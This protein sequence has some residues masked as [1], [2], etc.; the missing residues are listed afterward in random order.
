MGIVIFLVVAV[1][2]LGFLGRLVLDDSLV[3]VPPGWTGLVLIRGRSERTI[4]SVLAS[5]AADVGDR[6]GA[7][8]VRLEGAVT[9]TSFR[10]RVA[11]VVLLAGAW[12][13]IADTA[14]PIA[15]L[16]TL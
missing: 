8:R 10:V 14:A 5:A 11:R 12:L 3:R 9:T 1:P 15:D 4:R 6:F 2:V 16:P 7:G 13:A